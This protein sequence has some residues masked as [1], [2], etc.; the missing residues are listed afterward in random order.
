MRRLI[1][2]FTVLAFS[3]TLFLG[4][5]QAQARYWQ[6]KAEKTNQS[7]KNKPARK[8]PKLK[9]FAEVKK[10]YDK[11]VDGLFTFYID[12]DENKVLMAI[13]KDQLDKL[14][15]CNMTRSRGDGAY[16]DAGAQTGD[17]PFHFHRVGDNMQ[18]MVSNLLIRADTMSAMSRAVDNSISN[19]IFANTK[20]LSL[21]DTSGKVL[22]DPSELFV[23][24][25][26]NV[27]YFLGQQGKTGFH[28]DPKNSNFGTIKSFPKNSEI[29]VTLSYN[30]NKPSDAVL[31][32]PYNIMLKYHFSLSTIPESSDFRPRV[33]DDRVGYFLTM[34][35][36][37]S[38]LDTEQPYIRYINRWNLK[39]KDPNADV[40]EPVKPI[41]YWIDNATPKEYIPAVKAGLEYWNK[42]FEK[43]AG[44]KDA[45]DIRVMPD[46]ATWDPADVRYNTIRWFVLP[47][48]GYAVGPSR[49]N[50]FTGEIYD[51]DVR[52]SADFIRFMFNY[53]NR[54]IE[55][56]NTDPSASGE[57][58]RNPG[59]GVWGRFP[60]YEMC[61]Y[62]Q[63][64]AMEGA[65]ALAVLNARNTLTDKPKLT[66]KFVNEYI[67]DLV[68]HEVGHTLGL[69]HNFKAS[70]IY[71]RS[72]Q[73]DPNFVAT[74]AITGTVME[75]SPANLVPEGQPQTDFYSKVPGPYDLWAIEYGY[76]EFNNAKD[77]WEEYNKDLKP[78]AAR[79]G[80]TDL[81]YGT[82][83]DCFGNSPRSVDPY[84]TQFDLGS[85]PIDYWGMRCDLSNEL[86]SKVKKDFEKPGND[87]TKLR[88]VF[89]Y[90]WGAFSSGGWNVARFIGGYTHDRNHV[91][92]PGTSAPFT[93]V[94]AS[95]QRQA[96]SFLID[97]IWSEDAF[98]FDSDLLNKLQP[99]RL[100]DFQFSVYQMR[101]LDY[102][103]HAQVASVQARPLGYIYDPTTLARINDIG[104]HYAKGDDV[105]TMTD[106]FQDVR[107]AI[108]KEA[109]EN[110][111]VNSF[112][113]NLQR[114]HLNILVDMVTKKQAPMMPADAI[115][116]ARHDLRTI[117][118]ALQSAIN[119][120]HLNTISASHYRDSI[121]KI[122]A[123]LA[124]SLKLEI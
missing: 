49:A 44:I 116:L 54:L 62:A 67:S 111:N 109:I 81:A 12:E 47:G 55:P 93:P 120:G 106:I 53:A 2:L 66:Q 40:S 48:A 77:Q 61:D 6:E 97:R 51:A 43:S 123:A 19:S 14:F 89:N 59:D 121:A 36:D 41:V 82:D 35:E 65:E 34:Y 16:F 26:P 10:D 13:G 57:V 115:T 95:K 50:P 103:V 15:L 63:K 64:A 71:P 68:A 75:Y 8:K 70:S 32:S 99:E 42:V 83:E 24:D 108:W 94:P 84:A 78:I 52:I 60:N 23:S 98:D 122:D 101:R 5:G 4:V 9:P 113:R 92:D 79:C 114:E 85:D 33:A 117:K 104:L 86:W 58:E 39:K 31:P 1:V 11:K 118:G 102:P 46:T 112:R 88:N 22:I 17:F 100:P 7:A 21:P 45:I 110:R 107:R 25:V 20:V 76:K 29:D 91:G 73:T 119:S 38:E 90:G 74:H 72:E 105:Y 3:A 80:E 18:M 37:Y 69:R 28:F 124:A 96:M 27:G 30:T 87:Y 56:I